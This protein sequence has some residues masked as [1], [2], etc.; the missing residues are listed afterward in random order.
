MAA[1]KKKPM[2][3][4]EKKF[5]AKMKKKMQEEGI[6]PMDKPKLNRKKY[7]DDAREEWNKKD[8]DCLIW[9]IYLYKA[10]GITLGLTDR[11]MRA[12]PEAVGVA[13]T[14]KLAIRLK[15]FE[16]KVKAEGRDKYNMK[17]Y[18]EFIQ[19]ILNA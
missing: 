6:I 5:N 12:S 9:D 11:N 7:I 10:I 19:D 16:D 2:T 8:G 1:K 17:E 13:K 4:A 3:Q 15:E 14:L 18:F